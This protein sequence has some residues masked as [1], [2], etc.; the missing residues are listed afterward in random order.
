MLKKKKML[1]TIY[2]LDSQDSKLAIMRYVKSDFEAEVFNE[3]TELIDNILE[4]ISKVGGSHEL[5]LALLI[6]SRHL[7]KDLNFYEPIKE[8]FIKAA[9]ADGYL[10]SE[11]EKNQVLKNL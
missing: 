4:D 7:R 8:L 3:E 2:K 11:K 9:M 1:H 6:S 10:K 5:L